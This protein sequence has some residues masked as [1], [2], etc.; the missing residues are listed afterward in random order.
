MAKRVRYS[1]EEA[2]R[3]ILEIHDGSDSDDPEFSGGDGNI[4]DESVSKSS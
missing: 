2:W 3:I 1:V 4:E